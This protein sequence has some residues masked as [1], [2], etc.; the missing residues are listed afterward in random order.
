MQTTLRYS[1]YGITIHLSIVLLIRPDVQVLV[2]NLLRSRQT[3]N[4]GRMMFC[5]SAQDRNS[6]DK[7]DGGIEEIMGNDAVLL[8]RNE[9]LYRMHAGDGSQGDFANRAKPSDTW[10]IHSNHCSFDA[11]LSLR[12]VHEAILPCPRSSP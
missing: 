8:K 9:L 7:D 12:N 11:S 5:D 3:L 1:D 10:Q 2:V 4:G 6:R